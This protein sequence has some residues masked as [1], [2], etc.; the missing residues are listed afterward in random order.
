MCTVSDG[1]SPVIVLVPFAPPPS[2]HFP[3]P[4]EC[5]YGETVGEGE[6]N[7]TFPLPFL[8]GSCLNAHESPNEHLP[9][10]VQRMQ[11][12]SLRVV[13]LD[14]LFSFSFRFPFA[15]SSSCRSVPGSIS[16]FEMR[17]LDFLPEMSLDHQH[18]SSLV[19]FLVTEC[20]LL[21]CVDLQQ[22]CQCRPLSNLH[23]VQVL[24]YVVSRSVSAC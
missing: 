18:Q 10:V 13:C 19:V 17:I 7:H 15:R 16:R 12:H 23:L 5:R 9:F 24:H 21:G 2:Q 22:V 14:V 4:F 8:F 20:C 11:S 6:R 1:H 3:S